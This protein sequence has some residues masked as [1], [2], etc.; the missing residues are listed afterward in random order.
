MG[1]RFSMDSERKRSTRRV[2]DT[3]VLATADWIQD[4]IP[5]GLFFTG[6]YSNDVLAKKGWVSDRTVHRDFE[7]ALRQAGYKGQ[8]F[9]AF[10]DNGGGDVHCH[11]ILENTAAANKV[12]YFWNKANGCYK[13]GSA[14]REAYIY[15]ANRAMKTGKDGDHRYKE[16]FSLTSSN[17]AAA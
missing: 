11:A 9:V 14:D 15:V 10:H 13:C 2:T 12:R 5:D 17:E 16:N 6:T 1:S 8:Y 4:Q 7:Y 3:V